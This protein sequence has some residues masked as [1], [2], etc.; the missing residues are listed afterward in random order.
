MLKLII[1]V[2]QMRSTAR[3]PMIAAAPTAESGFRLLFE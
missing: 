2:L 3:K 1:V